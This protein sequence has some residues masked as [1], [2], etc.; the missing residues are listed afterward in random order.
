MQ[1]F[2]FDTGS[3]AHRW[4]NLNSI[5]SVSKGGNG[6]VIIEFNNESGFI[7][8]TFIHTMTDSYI[9]KLTESTDRRIVIKA[10]SVEP[11]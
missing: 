7:N 8:V 11:S 10:E 1:F 9:D 6:T 2:G 3:G 4:Y 5:E